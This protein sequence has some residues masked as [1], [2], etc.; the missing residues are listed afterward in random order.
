MRVISSWR[1][2]RRAWE[3]L[4]R[5]DETHSIAVAATSEGPTACAAAT[6]PPRAVASEV[7]ASAAAVLRCDS[8]AARAVEIAAVVGGPKDATAEE[9]AR[10]AALVA[11]VVSARDSTARVPARPPYSAWRKRWGGR[12]EEGGEWLGVKGLGCK[13]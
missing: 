12:G 1:D 8:T 5:M 2:A 3:R 10:H 13:G 6:T 4:I 7:E 9:R 11:A